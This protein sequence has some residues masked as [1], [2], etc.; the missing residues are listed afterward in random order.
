[1]IPYLKPRF[2]FFFFLF[3]FFFFLFSFFFFCTSS[4]LEQAGG[5]TTRRSLNE[6][7][8][9]TAPSSIFNPRRKKRSEQITTAFFF[10]RARGSPP[11]APFPP[12]PLAPS[13]PPTHLDEF[14]AHGVEHRSPGVVEDDAPR[15]GRGVDVKR[16]RDERVR[17]VVVCELCVLEKGNVFETKCQFTPLTF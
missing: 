1:M 3:S 12:S 5:G 11:P 2:S 9:G 10:K 4:R 16:S 14:L 6:Y 8:R 13:F 17:V 15:V 7:H